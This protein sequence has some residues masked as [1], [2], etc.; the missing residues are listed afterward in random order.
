MIK[1]IIFDFDATLYNYFDKYY[2]IN[3]GWTGFISRCLDYSLNAVGYKDRDAFIKKYHLEDMCSYFRISNGMLDEFGTNQP[4]IDFLNKEYFHIPDESKIK[5]IDNEILKD[6]HKNYKLYIVSGSAPIHVKGY[7][8][9]GKID[10]NNFDG[11]ACCVRKNEKVSKVGCYKDVLIKENIKPSEVLVIGDSMT[12]DLFPGMELGMHV[13]QTKQ[14]EN[15]KQIIESIDAYT[16]TKPNKNVC[17]N[18]QPE[19]VP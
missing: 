13:Q 12:S 2:T 17:K 7:M 1:A 15:I 6:L 4:V 16:Q 3:S 5:F 14:L 19:L 11:I 10:V 18:T 8:K 9:V